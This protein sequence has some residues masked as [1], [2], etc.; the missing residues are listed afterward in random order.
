LI[1]WKNKN[2]KVGMMEKWNFDKLSYHSIFHHSIFSFFSILRNHHSK[3][4]IPKN[5]FF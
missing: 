4:Q 2:W 1:K 3:K 5:T